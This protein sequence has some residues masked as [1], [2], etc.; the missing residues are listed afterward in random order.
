MKQILFSTG[1][2]RQVFPVTYDTKSK[3][4]GAI[5]DSATQ[6]EI[7]CHPAASLYDFDGKR[8][9]TAGSQI[10]KDLNKLIDSGPEA[11]EDRE[12]W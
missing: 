10:S 8:P 9:G 6:L 3:A 2:E 1:H 5:K 7:S 4:H 12:K 11:V